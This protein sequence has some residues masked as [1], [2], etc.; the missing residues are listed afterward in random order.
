[1]ISI[2][3]LVFNLRIHYNKFYSVL[4][5]LALTYEDINHLL[6]EI[7]DMDE[8]DVRKIHRIFIEI[9]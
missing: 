7:N 8:E 9:W 2:T 1:M 5:H 3:S 4:I 6:H